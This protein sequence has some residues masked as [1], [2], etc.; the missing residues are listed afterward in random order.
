MREYRGCTV[1]SCGFLGAVYFVVVATA[2][3]FV[4]KE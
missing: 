4:K 3:E 1:D 2:R